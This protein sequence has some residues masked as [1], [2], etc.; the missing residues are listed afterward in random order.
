[1]KRIILITILQL[2]C[3]ALISQKKV[4]SGCSVIT[5]SKDGSVFFSGND[6]YIN[7]DQ[8]YWVEPGDSSKYGVIWIGTPDNPQQGVNEKG[9][10]Y[11][12]NGLPRF[13]VNP[14]P[15]RIPVTGEYYHNY[16]MQIMHECSTVTEVIEWANKHQ[17][18]PY[19]HDQMH[20]A[21]KTGDAVIISAGND[22]EMVF[23]RKTPGDGFLVSTN[24]NVANPA[25]AYTYP[26]WRYDKANEMLGQLINR[27][28]SLNF[29]D[30]TNVM[31]AVHQESAS[32]TIET[33]V[34]DLVNGVIYLYYFYQYDN[35]VIINVKD[36]LTNPREAGP[37]SKLFPEDVQQEAANRYKQMTK[38]I[39]INNVVGRSWSALIIFSMILLLIIPQGNKGLRFWIP[40][41]LVLGP[42]ALAA[43]ILALNPAKTSIWRKAL[44]ETVGNMVSV[45]I[46]YLVALIIMIFKLISGGIGQQQQALLILAFPLLASWIIFQSPLLAL[47]GK[48]NFFKFLFQRLPQVLVTTFLILGGIF[49]VSMILVNRTIVM[50]QIIPL[51]PW[52]V[53]TWLTIIVA[54]SLIG[55]IFVFF[56]EYWATR[57]EYRAWNI[58]A[59][60]EGEVTTPQWGKIWRWL[61]ISVLI[62]FAG[63]IIGVMLL[64]ATAG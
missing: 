22:G 39:R 7:P 57:R 29:N 6:D 30:I 19:M 43:R 45:V 59:G 12:S 3:L 16:L 64:K 15:E 2:C 25:N 48:K 34:A 24:F 21:D 9:L 20:F 54:G 50:S 40:A 8:Y 5:I 35:P 62:I 10:A 58:Y 27:E 55:G 23:T 33:L 42:F 53:I 41:V 61:I 1:M 14:H 13:E 51:S 26:C 44:I 60:D 47:T 63:L 49:P 52:I 4:P 18:F 56:Y 17:R 31:D 28:E 38:S 46:A 36:E 32:W 37:L 11:D